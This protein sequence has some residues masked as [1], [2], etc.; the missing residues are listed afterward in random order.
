MREQTGGDC[1]GCLDCTH[2]FSVVAQ[3]PVAAVLGVFQMQRLLYSALT[4]FLYQQTSQ[5]KQLF[6]ALKYDTQ[7]KLVPDSSEVMRY[8]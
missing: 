8:T 1:A 6:H 2:V 4:V 7:C 3:L 5:R